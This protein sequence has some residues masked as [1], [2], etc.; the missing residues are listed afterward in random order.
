MHCTWTVLVQ[1][2]QKENVQYFSKI[3]SKII[4]QVFYF[5]PVFANLFAIDY[6]LIRKFLEKLKKKRK[7]N[8]FAFCLF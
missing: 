8:N 6:W 1:I 3:N 7:R 2:I 4:Y 5:L